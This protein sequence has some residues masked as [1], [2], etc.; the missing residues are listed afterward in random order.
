M[1]EENNLITPH[2]SINDS[3][4]GFA[5]FIEFSYFFPKFRYTTKETL[6]FRMKH[7]LS[8]EIAA[9]RDK[10][11]VFEKV[12]QIFD[13]TS[14]RFVKGLISRKEI[15]RFR[16]IWNKILRRIEGNVILQRKMLPL[17]RNYR[18]KRGIIHFLWDSY[19][20]LN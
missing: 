18:F 13:S 19:E 5:R 17:E 10:F 4:G 7:R 8:G 1:I 11:Q 6:Y 9:L 2:E 3:N 20:F 16:A 12:W 15:A 14:R